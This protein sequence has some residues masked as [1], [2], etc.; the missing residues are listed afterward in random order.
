M[1]F[2]LY[3][4]IFFKDIFCNFVI[5]LGFFSSEKSI[6]S[7]LSKGIMK[8]FES[9]GKFCFFLGKLV[10]NLTFLLLFFSLL[11]NE[12]FKETFFFS[13][14]FDEFSSF[15]S[16]SLEILLFEL[17]SLSRSTAVVFVFLKGN[18]IFGSKLLLLG[19]FFN[20]LFLI[21]LLTISF[22]FSLLLL[23]STKL[24]SF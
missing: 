18:F 10:L 19:G 4:I 17:L 24:F 13:F 14:F 2:G 12:S 1:N 8:F 22:I 6:S 9:N 15:F 7:S 23:S 3:T 11:V 5:A 21:S 16:L 20:T